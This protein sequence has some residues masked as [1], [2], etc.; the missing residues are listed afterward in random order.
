M[1]CISPV[2]SS[3]AAAGSSERD[4]AADIERASSVSRGGLPAFLATN[5]P[6]G[7]PALVH[8]FRHYPL[9]LT[10]P[11]QARSE[12]QA[13]IRS[14]VTRALDVDERALPTDRDARPYSGQISDMLEGAAAH[15]TGNNALPGWS[16]GRP[17]LRE[18]KWSGGTQRGAGHVV[19]AILIAIASDLGGREVDQDP[20]VVLNARSNES[21]LTSGGLKKRRV[22]RELLNRLGVWPW[23]HVAGGKL[24]RDWDGRPNVHDDLDAALTEWLRAQ[25]A[26][27]DL[28][29]RAADRVHDVQ[30]TP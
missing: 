27:P 30:L 23:A 9:P 26:L 1:S 28:M 3:P 4:G 13:R 12:T 29:Q 16:P 25:R 2:T 17:Y 20:L 11:K 14:Y 18:W 8:P 15:C 21:D 19:S 5:V 22:G 24:P 6:P 7:A 10:V